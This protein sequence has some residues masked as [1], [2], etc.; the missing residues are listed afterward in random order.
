M[1]SS[2]KKKKFD[3]A[4]PVVTIESV[5]MVGLDNVVVTGNISSAGADDIEYCGFAFSKSPSFDILS[6]QVLIEGNTKGHFHA[7]VH[8]DHDSTYYFKAFA[9]NGLGYK[10]S[11]VLR[12]TVPVPPPVVAPCT[13]TANY[14]HDNGF[15]FPV[16][17]YGSSVS[18]TYGNYEVSIYSSAASES[19]LLYFPYKPI[20]G[21]YT[22]VSDGWS[23]GS[24][25]VLVDILKFNYYRVNSGGKVYVNVDNATGVTTITICDVNYTYSSIDFDVY[26]KV[27]YN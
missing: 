21:I 8:A 7:T 22:T 10:V 26:G 16:S 20:N 25:E 12:Y 2:C 19:I 17:A 23:I 27:S 24:G 11:N 3:D 15:G 5:E 4:L 6:N 13:L 18:P 1:L 14:F 9:A